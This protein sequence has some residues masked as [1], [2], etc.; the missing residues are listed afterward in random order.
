MDFLGLLEFLSALGLPLPLSLILGYLIVKILLL[1]RR[2]SELEADQHK[3]AT[4]NL[5]CRYIRR[6]T[7]DLKMREFNKSGKLAESL[8]AIRI[9][10]LEKRA[11][12]IEKIITKIYNYLKRG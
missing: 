9:D 1:E 5:L 3:L 6:D 8:N 4:K 7:C 10:H 12:H 11:T 2:V